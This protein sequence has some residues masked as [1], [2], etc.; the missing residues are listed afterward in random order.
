MAIRVQG[1]LHHKLTRTGRRCVRGGARSCI[2]RQSIVSK[3][4]NLYWS[5]II[6]RPCIVQ[7]GIEYPLYCSA[8]CTLFASGLIRPVMF[9]AMRYHAYTCAS[10]R[11]QQTTTV[12]QCCIISYYCTIIYDIICVYLS[13]SISLSL[14]IYINK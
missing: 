9:H 14:S 2:V 10:Q 13:L 4:I 3:H 11:C 7:P 6:R 1:A 8:P 12:A 5:W